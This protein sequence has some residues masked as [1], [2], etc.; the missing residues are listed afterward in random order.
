MLTWLIL[1]LTCSTPWAPRAASPERTAAEVLREVRSRGNDA[2]AALFEELGK[3]KSDEACEALI[4]GLGSLSKVDKVCTGFRSFRHFSGVAG[5]QERAVEYLVARAGASDAKLA[6]H[7]TLRLGELW[8]A[9]REELIELALKDSDADRRSV[10]LMHLVEHDATFSAKEC[11]QLARSSDPRVRYEGLLALVRQV[12]QPSQRIGKLERM[13]RD[14]D[15]LER[16]AAVEVLSTESSPVRVELLLARLD[17]KDP[18]VRR[19]ALA[20]LERSREVAVVGELVGRLAGANDGERYRYTRALMRLTGQSLGSGAERW[21]RWWAAEGATFVLPAEP[22][23]PASSSA[24]EAEGSRATFYGLPIYDD[25]V[26]FAIDTSDS[27]KAAVGSEGTRIQVAKR[28]LTR[29]LEA[30]PEGGAFDVVNF[31]KSAWSWKGELV[32]ATSRNKRAALKHVD[33]LELS[34]GTEQFLALREAFRDPSA[35]SILM[36]TDGDPQLSLVMDRGALRR[37]VAQWNRTR[38]TALDLITVG[39]D[40]PWLENISA[41]SGGRYRRIE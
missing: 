40:R 39:T 15:A 2:P 25:H 3:L 16:L 34:W 33:Y 31:G 4:D 27:M 19:K 7:A 32:Q 35:D 36:M 1:A 13:L 22:V 11:K 29:A 9:C 26:L 12:E 8:P 21:E 20:S 17:D 23:E 41:D 10:A 24:A 18:C 28:E 30:F 38:H 5:A 6:L 37:I 14:S